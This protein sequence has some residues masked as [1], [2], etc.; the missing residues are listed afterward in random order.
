MFH[1][2]DQLVALLVS[3]VYSGGLQKG[4]WKKLPAEPKNNT[5]R[6]VRLNQTVKPQQ[7]TTTMKEAKTGNYVKK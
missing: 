1:Y 7:K 3:L 2:V 4:I 6:A 5:M